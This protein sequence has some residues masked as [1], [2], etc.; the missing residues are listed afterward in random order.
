MILPKMDQIKH[1]AV[2]AKLDILCLSEK[3]LLMN[4]PS[5]ILN[6]REYKMF[7]RDRSRGKGVRVMFDIRHLICSLIEWSSNVKR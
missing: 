1:H 5:V 2:D 4:S 6:G 3:W 7:R